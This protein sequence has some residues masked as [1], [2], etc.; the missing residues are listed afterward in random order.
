[1]LP[2]DHPFALRTLGGG[3]LSCALGVGAI[4]PPICFLAVGALDLGALCGGLALLRDC[5]A[6][7]SLATS[8]KDG[9][10]FYSSAA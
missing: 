2:V 3:A 8:E 10:E 1:L 9:N 4:E 6:T 5:A 7:W